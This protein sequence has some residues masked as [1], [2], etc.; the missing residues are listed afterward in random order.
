MYIDRVVCQS[1]TFVDVD[2]D[3]RGS[4]SNGMRKPNFFL[5]DRRLID[6]T[7]RTARSIKRS[8]WKNVNMILTT[9]GQESF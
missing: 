9:S 4:R 7:Y 8:I 6:N 3:F 1:M 5:I 2:A